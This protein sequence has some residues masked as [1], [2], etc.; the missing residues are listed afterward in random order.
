MLMAFGRA[1]QI[2]EIFEVGFG[3]GTLLHLFQ[4]R[5]SAAFGTGLSRPLKSAQLPPGRVLWKSAE[6]AVCAGP[7]RFGGLPRRNPFKGMTERGF[8]PAN[9]SASRKF[10][11]ASHISDELRP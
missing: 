10:T 1:P 7:I 11:G 9:T 2:H 6:H 4:E 3:H 5:I 8:V